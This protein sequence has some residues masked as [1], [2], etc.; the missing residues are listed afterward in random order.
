[1]K[2]IVICIFTL[3]ALVSLGCKQQ[4]NEEQSKP[5]EVIEKVTSVES[6]QNV[7]PTERYFTDTPV[8]VI[9]NGEIEYTDYDAFFEKWKLFTGKE[10]DI[11]TI[12]I[13]ETDVQDGDSNFYMVLASSTD[14][15]TKFGTLLTVRDSKLYYYA[16]QD[17][18]IMIMCKG[19]V[20]DCDVV[21]AYNGGVA[22]LSCSEGCSDC[23][24]RE[25]VFRLKRSE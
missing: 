15:K 8:A 25:G 24:K 22:S 2:S 6:Q 13:K 16:A 7:A 17:M 4:K 1:M 14:K 12:E 3:F 10:G 5:E 18:V 9:K 21:V 11:A 23:I 20:D 19:C